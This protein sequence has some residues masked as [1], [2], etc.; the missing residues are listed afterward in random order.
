LVYDLARTNP[1]LDSHTILNR[2]RMLRKPV[3]SKSTLSERPP[4]PDDPLPLHMP[5]RS[6][7]LST[8]RKQSAQ[9]N[10][11]EQR[12]SC[13]E[14]ATA[15]EPAPAVWGNNATDQ[16]ARGNTSGSSTGNLAGGKANEWV[17]MVFRDSICMLL[18]GRRGLDGDGT[19]WIAQ[20]HSLE[21]PTLAFTS[22]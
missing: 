19:T 20:G 12:T 11:P 9:S 10:S 2:I 1:P 7:A 21:R 8:A 5:E 22:T 6:Q 4:R 17:N 18:L 15:G 14:N 16:S 13:L 3:Q